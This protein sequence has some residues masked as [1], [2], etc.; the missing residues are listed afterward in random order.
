MRRRPDRIVRY[1]HRALAQLRG[2]ALL[3]GDE[4]VGPVP[5]VVGEAGE[6]VDDHGHGR[7][8]PQGLGEHRSVHR[9]AEVRVGRAEARVERE[10]AAPRPQRGDEGRGRTGVRG[11]GDQREERQAHGAVRRSTTGPHARSATRS[12]PA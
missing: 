4:H 8:R 7:R 10:R 12:R 5:H 11:P 2:G 1:E 3:A 6:R 9:E